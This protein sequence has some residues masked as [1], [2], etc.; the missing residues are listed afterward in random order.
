MRLQL[1]EAS[2]SVGGCI[3]CRRILGSGLL[4]L[5][6]LASEGGVEGAGWVAEGAREALADGVSETE[7][8]GDAWRAGWMAA[9]SAKW[10][11]CGRAPLEGSA[12]G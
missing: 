10:Y 8:R 12:H 6:L 11:G 4:L 3:L 7:I 5:L 1:G 9:E 2:D